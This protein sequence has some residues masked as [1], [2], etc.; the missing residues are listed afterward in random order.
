MTDMQNNL[1]WIDLEMTGLEPDKDHILEI[2]TIITNSNL[3]ILEEG[4]HFIIHQPEE[5]IKNM[6]PWSVD[7]HGKTGLTQAVRKSNTTLE[8]AERGTFNFIRRYCEPE[9]GLLAGNSVWQ[10][11]VFLKKYMPALVDYLFYRLIDVT[12]VK[13]L[14]MRWYP[15]STEFEKKDT[16][17][18]LE[19]IKES[20]EELRY[21]RKHFFK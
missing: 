12:T 14:V 20:I 5:V 19:D 4:P 13:E 2:A 6:H 11:R 16:H 17:R 9:T 10:D 7:Q 18:A 3:D 21:Y 8:Q 15:K 1:V